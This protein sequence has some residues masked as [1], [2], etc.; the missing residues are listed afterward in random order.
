M[1]DIATQV[2]AVV[3]SATMNGRR[4]EAGATS[5]AL[6]KI[7]VSREGMSLVRG[8]FPLEESLEKLESGGMPRLNLVTATEVPT[9]ARPLR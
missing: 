7:P 6:A 9:T 3:V 2:R 4:A 1:V 5:L 8:H